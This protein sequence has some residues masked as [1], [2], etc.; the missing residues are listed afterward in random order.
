MERIPR[1]YP[2]TAAPE[3][4]PQQYRAAATIDAALNATVELL[5][6]RP[7]D[8]IALDAIG[9]RAGVSHG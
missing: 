1:T 4:V 8:T 9:E 6:Q 5:E 3:P 2:S 7:L